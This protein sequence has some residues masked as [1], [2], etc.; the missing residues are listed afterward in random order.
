MQRIIPFIVVV[1]LT[2]TAQTPAPRIPQEPPPEDIIR[3]TTNL[4]QTYAVVTDKN[5]QLISDLKLEDF[6]L[7]EN[8]KKQEIKFLEFVGVD[9]GKRVEGNPPALPRGVDLEAPS[10]ISTANLK[11]V[12]GFVVDDLTIPV[13]DMSRVRDLLA[14]FVNNQ[15]REG[16]LVAIIRVVGGNPLLEQFTDDK[17]LLRTAIARLT[18]R[19]HPLAGAD[20]TF[21]SNV[22][23]AQ[24]D[25]GFGTQPDEGLNAEAQTTNVNKG[26]RSLMVLSTANALVTSLRSVP[27]RK[28]VVLFSGGLPL[29]EMTEQG[30]VIDR[31]TQETIPVDEVRPLFFDSSAIINQL[32]DN[33]ARSGVVINT[34]DVRGLQA[35]PG[36]RGFQDTPAKSSLGMTV[37]SASVGGGGMDP[38]FG[39]TPD[40]SV[41]AGGDALAGA[42]G[43]RT[44]ANATGGIA[45]VNTNNFRGGLDKIL[46]R[47]QGYYLLGYSPS[48]KFD[49]KFHKISI[50]VKREG[51]HVYARTG[52]FARQDERPSEQTTKE[53]LVI[54]AA[55]SPLMKSELG[56]SSV[57]QHKFLTTN[58]AE[59][60]IHLF[61]DPKTLTF[62]QNAQGKHQTSFE[63]VGFVFDLLG[64]ARGGFSETVNANLSPTEYQKAQ[65][66]GLSYS[67]H[68]ELP[69]GNF[70]LRAVVRENGTGKIGSTSRYLEVPDLAKKQLT[71]SSLFLFA[72]EPT[73]SGN[74]G[75]TP[76]TA[77]RELTRKQELRYAAIIYNPKITNAKT[78]LRTQLIVTQQGKVIFAEPEQTLTGP[79]KDAQVIQVGQLGLTRVPPGKYTLSL[80]V[81]DTSDK[82][83]RRASRT[84]DF[85]VVD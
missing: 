20:P 85:T 55:V 3:I 50:K 9:T 80:V 40:M 19:T 33:A 70:Q 1:A 26:F 49:A 10:G 32:A 25:T 77:K 81:N 57:I 43:L 76:L 66:L 14:D 5:D 22:T 69:A 79:V 28:T 47:S 45:S 61:I 62:T 36:V 12:I 23:G 52:Y 2:A 24:T 75:I 7:Y 8:G 54:R 71:M 16:D 64:K 67:A 82:K 56:V 11:R 6:E 78:D 30:L 41:L 58:R 59:L 37:G 48:E 63:V 4:V 44:L 34:M 74:A 31:S 84:M 65:A 13:E 83:D 15:M 21:A 29:F 51:A 42:Q 72:I 53:N 60:D 68:T 38:G 17:Q 27:G 39:R 73:Q 18:S 35:R 46:A